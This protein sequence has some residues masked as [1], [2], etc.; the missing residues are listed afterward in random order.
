MSCFKKQVLF[1]LEAKGG[2]EGSFCFC[3][4]LFAVGK[5]HHQRKKKQRILPDPIILR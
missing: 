2:E 3:F 5:M 1:L 4:I